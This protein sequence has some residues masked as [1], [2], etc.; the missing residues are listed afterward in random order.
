MLPFVVIEYLEHLDVGVPWRGFTS[1][2]CVGGGGVRHRRW[3]RRLAKLEIRQILPTMVV[4]HDENGVEVAG[5][6]W[7][8]RS[9]CA[10]GVCYAGA[11][12]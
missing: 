5:C 6:P 11:A 12:F 9:R 8:A 3:Y 10:A 2:V 1:V 4:Q 7:G